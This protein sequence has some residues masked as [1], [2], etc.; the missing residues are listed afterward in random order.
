MRRGER[1]RIRGIVDELLSNALNAGA[2]KVD[3]TI[4]NQETHWEV[5]VRDDGRGMAPERVSQVQELLRQPRRFELEEYYGD[6]AGVADFASGLT[7]VGILV[8]GAQVES[9]LGKG[10]TVT[11]RRDHQ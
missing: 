8:D 7:I 10:T 9:E 11:V 5:T 6:L 3:V 4:T 1:H 2:K